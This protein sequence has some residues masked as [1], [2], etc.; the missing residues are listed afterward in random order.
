MDCFVEKKKIFYQNIPSWIYMRRKA[1]RLENCSEIREISVFFDLIND[2]VSIISKDLIRFAITNKHPFGPYWLTLNVFIACVLVIDVYYYL[3][4]VVVLGV[5]EEEAE[6][7][8][9]ENRCLEGLRFEDEGVRLICTGLFE[10]A[11]SVGHHFCTKFELSP[12]RRSKYSL[13]SNPFFSLMYSISL[14]FLSNP[15]IT[16][17]LH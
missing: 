14:S 13:L 12:E 8:N 2:E 4:S 9:L 10:D 7:E 17:N 15:L 5:T 11:D 6:V 16:A 1:Y 3:G